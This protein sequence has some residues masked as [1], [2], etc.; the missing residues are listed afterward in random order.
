MD[1]KT[2][3]LATIQLT[4]AL[5][6][7]Y[8]AYE[9]A[10]VAELVRTEGHADWDGRFAF[11]HQ[12][13][14]QMAKLDVLTYQKVRALVGDWCTQQGTLEAVRRRVELAKTNVTTATA[15][16]RPPDPKEQAIIDRAGRE[17]PELGRKDQLEERYGLEA[18]RA[19][20]RSSERVL[21]S[22]REVA[23]LEGCRHL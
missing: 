19:L 15:A 13:A 3:R 20:E 16:E 21:A 1:V 5:L 6:Q 14:L 23:R 22:H 18:V 9:Q 4:E 17:L 2:L 11:A 8:L 7:Q 10:L 12:H